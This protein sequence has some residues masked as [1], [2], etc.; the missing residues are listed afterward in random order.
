MVSADGLI[1]TN[2][3]VV[4]NRRRVRVRLASGEF[5]DAVVR[6]VDQAADIATIK[7]EP[8]VPGSSKPG[9][10]GGMGLP[11]PWVA[12]EVFGNLGNWSIVAT[13]AQNLDCRCVANSGTGFLKLHGTVEGSVSRNGLI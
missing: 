12:Q 10:G 2:A 7:I 13:S 9:K 11:D 6:Q 4:A 8:K 1:V 3:H 5:Y